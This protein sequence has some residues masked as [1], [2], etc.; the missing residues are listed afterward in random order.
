MT[1]IYYIE[2]IVLYNRLSG[3][4][5]GWISHL[6]FGKMRFQPDS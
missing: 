4:G 1:E 6:I 2:L 5:S 3:S